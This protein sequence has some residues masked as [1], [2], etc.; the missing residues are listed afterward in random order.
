MNWIT[1]NGTAYNLAAFSRAEASGAG[2]TLYLARA[3]SVSVPDPD[4]MVR[5]VLGLLPPAPPPTSLPAEA[6]PAASGPAPAPPTSPAA[7]GKAGRRP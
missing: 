1:V 5:R 6:P 4:G 7:K 3:Q 2:V